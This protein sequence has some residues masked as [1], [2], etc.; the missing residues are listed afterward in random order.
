MSARIDP[1]ATDTIEFPC[2]CEGSPHEVDTVTVRSEYGY[3]DL[4]E[5]QRKSLRFVPIDKDGETQVVT[6]SDPEA[7]HF[8]L[9]EI[10]VK[11]WTFLEDDG[12]PMELSLPNIRTLRDDIGNTIADRI[13]A[14]YLAAKERQQLPNPSSGR[15]P[16]SSSETSSASTNRAQ[17]RAAKRSSPRSSSS[18]AGQT[19]S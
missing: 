9:L 12:S 6:I 16:A 11:A 19:T 8:A 10:G 17:R 7:E 4:T 3:G 14:L 1:E 18:P 15:S 2:P 13:N 5:I